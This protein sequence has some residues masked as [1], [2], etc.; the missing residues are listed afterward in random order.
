MIA[1]YFVIHRGPKVTYA[2]KYHDF[3]PNR[4]P[5]PAVYKLRL[6]RLDDPEK[7]C[8]MSLAEL[9]AMYERLRA[10]G[11]L[12]AENLKAPVAPVVSTVVSTGG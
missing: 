10:A 9:L 4:F 2:A 3:L 8:A 6:D 11:K 1:V 7:W 12:P 5:D